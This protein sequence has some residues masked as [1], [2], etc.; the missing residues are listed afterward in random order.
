MHNLTL[1]QQLQALAAG[2]FSSVELTQHYIKRIESHQDSLN[3][4]ITFTPELALEEAKKAD[5][6]TADK[7]LLNG[8][9]LALKD[10]FCTQ[11]VKTSC[12]SKMLDN[13]IAPYDEQW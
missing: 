11:G 8:I 7:P 13:F 5:Q 1:A 2:E 6:R 3:A 12:G 4:F 9:P 10:I